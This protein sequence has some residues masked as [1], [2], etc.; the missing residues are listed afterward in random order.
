MTL[1]THCGAGPVTFK[2][3][4]QL[5][6]P[7]ETKTY[8]P[9]RH[10]WLVSRVR[11][12]GSK[13][14]GEHLRS[15]YAVTKDGKRFF[16]TST[17][18][19]GVDGINALLGYRNSIDR[20]LALSFAGGGGVFVCDNMMFTGEEIRV[21]RHTKHVKH[22]A[23]LLLEEICQ[24]LASEEGG[25]G[26]F[27]EMIDLKNMMA[28]VELDDDQ[29]GAFLG[30]CYMHNALRPRQM[31]IAKREWKA[32]RHEEWLPRNA[33]SLY[34]ACTEALK[35]A[36]PNTV[37]ESYLTLN[38]L[39]VHKWGQPDEPSDIVTDI[40]VDFVNGEIETAYRDVAD[41]IEED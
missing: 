25:P 19:T 41:E 20:S 5:N 15:D 16:G 39:A 36:S 37:T 23:V 4:Q 2:Q 17:F 8:V 31:S 14:L 13:Y 6:Y 28:A 22:D 33:W 35:G 29:A 1:Y 9:V 7:E 3:L 18:D 11:E 38:R 30:V 34:N 10:D 12:Y 26:S 24:I 21:R 27:K 32:P 40:E